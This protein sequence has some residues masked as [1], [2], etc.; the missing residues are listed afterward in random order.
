[1]QKTYLRFAVDTGDRIQLIRKGNDY[2]YSF[3]SF[4]QVY[5]SVTQAQYFSNR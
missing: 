4:L 3:N 1:M 2:C 5:S